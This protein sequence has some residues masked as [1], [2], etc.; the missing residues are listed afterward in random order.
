MVE[1]V[2]HSDLGQIMESYVGLGL[3]FTIVVYGLFLVV[4]FS[5]VILMILIIVVS[6]RASKGL[7]NLSEK[8][9]RSVVILNLIFAS[10]ILGGSLL[11]NYCNLPG[12]TSESSVKAN[13]SEDRSCTEPAGRRAV[14][15]LDFFIL[16][17]FISSIFFFNR[18]E[19]RGQFNQG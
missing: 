17:Y 5:I 9:R 3:L 4:A 2:N 12:R 19:V 16:P 18:S 13:D 1:S 14:K 6:F 15:V 11:C 8:T 10:F 7:L